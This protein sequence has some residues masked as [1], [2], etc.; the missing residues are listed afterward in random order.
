M[1]ARIVVSVGGNIEKLQ[2]TFPGKFTGIYERFSGRRASFARID[3][4]DFASSERAFK[5]Q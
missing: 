4:T 2:N 1:C 5:F 3:D